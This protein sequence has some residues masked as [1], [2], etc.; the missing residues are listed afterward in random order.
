[1]VCFR[2]LMLSPH[3]FD[4]SADSI[5][6]RDYILCAGFGMPS[7]PWFFDWMFDQ[8]SDCDDGVTPAG[9]TKLARAMDL[10]EKE[11]QEA[12]AWLSRDRPEH[13]LSRA[14]LETLLR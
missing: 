1:M 9:V 3:A 5:S 12:A 6:L 14:Q 7:K 11:T 10:P 4:A 13:A 8:F 2:L